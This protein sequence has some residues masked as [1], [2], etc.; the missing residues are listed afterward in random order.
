M[1]FK[2]PL[3]SILLIPVF[4]GSV[5]LSARADETYRIVVKDA[6][7]D[8]EQVADDFEM[9]LSITA[10]A[11]GQEQTFDINNREQKRFREEVLGVDA[12]GHSNCVRRSY[13]VYR[14]KREE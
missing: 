9:K 6:V 2:R 1:R 5:L 3:F 13:S 4:M 12:A 7:G 14:K 11:A 8:V 10:S